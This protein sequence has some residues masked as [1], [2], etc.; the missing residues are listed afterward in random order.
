MQS[1]LEH[2]F[3]QVSALAERLQRERRSLD[4]SNGSGPRVSLRPLEQQLVQLWSAIRLERSPGGDTTVMR[5]HSKR[6]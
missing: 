2:L 4:E 6:G 5:R 1:P 3:E